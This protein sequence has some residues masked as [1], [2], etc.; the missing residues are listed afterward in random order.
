MAKN[1][2]LGRLINKGASGLSVFCEVSK[3]EAWQRLG[4]KIGVEANTVQRWAL[5]QVPDDLYWLDPLIKECVDY[6]RMDDR[7]VRSML[8]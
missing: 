6:G 2:A 1:K 5:G 4:E 7:W 3:G 8:R